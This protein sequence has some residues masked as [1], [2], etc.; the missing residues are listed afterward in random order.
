MWST[1][2]TCSCSKKSYNEC[3]LILYKM[4]ILPILTYSSTVKT[5]FNKTQLLKFTS[6][7][8]RASSIIGKPVDRIS[9]TI[10]HNISTMVS[11]CVRKEF[12][13]KI[14]DNY[15]ET[16]NHGKRTRKNGLVLKVPKIKLETSRVF[17]LVG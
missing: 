10:G 17:T 6:S 5:S 14:L 15:F 9:K 1:E 3:C 8:R 4:T 12:N 16:Q 2:T 13:H 7:E 11:K